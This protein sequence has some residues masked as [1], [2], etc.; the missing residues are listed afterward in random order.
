[1]AG[2]LDDRGQQWEHCNHCAKHVKIQ[3]LTTGFSPKWPEFNFVDLCPACAQELKGVQ[4]N[5]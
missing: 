4:K 1:M 2:M 3:D 5:A